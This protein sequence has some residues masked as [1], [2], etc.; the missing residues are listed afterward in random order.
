MNTKVTVRELSRLA[1]TARNKLL[2]EIAEGLMKLVS[3]VPYSEEEVSKSPSERAKSLVLQASAK[4]ALVSGTLALPPGPP[5]MLT[6][7]PDLQSGGSSDSSS[8]TSQRC[9]ENPHSSGRER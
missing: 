2:D 4:S 1:D 8:R 3:R 9:M 5:G 7:L 6:I